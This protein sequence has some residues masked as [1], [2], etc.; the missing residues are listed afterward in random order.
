MAG[1]LSGDVAAMKARVTRTAKSE[2]ASARSRD[3]TGKRVAPVALR[4]RRSASPDSLAVP[5]LDP[6]SSVPPAHDRVRRDL[7]AHDPAVF[8]GSA[9][10]A[11][12]PHRA[13]RSE[14]VWPVP[15][16][17]RRRAPAATPDAAAGKIPGGGPGHA[18][19]PA[20][21]RNEIENLSGRPMDHVRVHF[22][23]PR[24][25]RLNALAYT[26]GSDIYLGPGQQRHLPHE[27]WHVVQ[28]MQGRV[29]PTLRIG[30]AEI[31]DDPALEA[32]ADRPGA[33]APA[34]LAHPSTPRPPARS[35]AVVQRVK[36]P[37]E[38]DTISNTLL[39][40]HTGLLKKYET[41]GL[42]K[43]SALAKRIA[44]FAADADTAEAAYELYQDYIR[45]HYFKNN[46]F[47]LKIDI[48][49]QAE[50]ME[51]AIAK[52]K[53]ERAK[54]VAAVSQAR[55]P[56][57]ALP[58]A[59]LQRETYSK[60]QQQAV[61]RKLETTEIQEKVFAASYG[62]YEQL[63]SK[64]AADI[65]I[66]AEQNILHERPDPLHSADL[67][68]VQKKYK[69]ET[70][71]EALKLEQSVTMTR[72]GGQQV[73]QLGPYQPNGEKRGITDLVTDILKQSEL[74]SDELA[75]AIYEADPK[76]L[77]ERLQKKGVSEEHFVKIRALRHL[78]GIEMSRGPEL[79]VAISLE[80]RSAARGFTDFQDYLE[81]M[82][83]SGLNA[84]AD[85]K[86]ARESANEESYSYIPKNIR[87][88]ALASIKGFL[89]KYMASSEIDPEADAF[90]K[91]ILKEPS[92]SEAPSDDLIDSSEAL[93]RTPI[94]VAMEPATSETQSDSEKEEKS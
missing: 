72:R 29:R 15:P 51:K 47:L 78:Y 25:A 70:Y 56:R 59:P 68:Q 77:R 66:R 42:P 94:F 67:A 8:G 53:S 63:A 10:E 41:S 24:P 16:I 82:A 49:Q 85:L 11:R 50:K 58:N 37:E 55:V 39:K 87:T 19:L 31:N 26:Q 89:L 79:S 21:L 86:A 43:P 46:P 36:N 40:V 74:S 45:E 91:A 30:G 5:S 57:R 7:P 48:V 60:G 93:L 12:R 13:D 61:K 38:E 35:S 23:S 9:R 22:N 6:A 90:I 92:D 76:V 18:G 34:K 3:D 73:G 65:A 32:E 27:A 14:S 20:R 62:G 28:Q 1:L 44:G 52:Q 83:I 69:H 33:G 80:N 81:N 75:A 84:T 71:G 4:S 64:A 88:R 17:Q 2:P 54:A